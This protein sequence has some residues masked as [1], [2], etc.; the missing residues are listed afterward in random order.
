MIRPTN[1]RLRRVGFVSGRL[2]TRAYESIAGS[3]AKK[4]S[5]KFRERHPNQADYHRWKR[6]YLCIWTKGLK[7]LL[8]WPEDR[9]LEWTKRLHPILL[10]DD[11]QTFKLFSH[12]PAELSIG[13]LLITQLRIGPPMGQ[14]RASIARRL[15][16]AGIRGFLGTGN[17][18]SEY[19]DDDWAA[20][21]E[22]VRTILRDY[23]ADLPSCSGVERQE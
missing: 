17:N 2:E 19:G 12:F 3:M 16:F 22:R 18:V 23:G 6:E 7:A 9:T 11:P 8:G 4:S 21:R 13:Y 10:S 20:A 15:A 14:E 1:H 5:G